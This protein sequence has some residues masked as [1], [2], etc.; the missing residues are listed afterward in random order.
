MSR[1]SSETGFLAKQST[2][3]GIGNMLQ[4]LSSF[5][6]LPVYTRFLTTS[7]YGIKEIVTISTEVVAVL[8]STAVSMALF[9]IY[10]QYDEEAT[11]RQV[12]SS[13][14]VAVGG[15][16]LVILGILIYLSP[17]LSGWLLDDPDLSVYLV[18]S[19]GALWFQV[20]NKISFDYMRARQQA[21]RVVSFSLAKLVMAL[22]LNVW[23]IV[24]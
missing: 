7:D 19:F 5:L 6:L 21:I 12:V 20:Q 22:G 13:A 3:Y 18:L 24:F 8:I 2:I 14:Y 17:P 10:F 4:R 9:R 16:G 11:R 23:F 1:I 15:F